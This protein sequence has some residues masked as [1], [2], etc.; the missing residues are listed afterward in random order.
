MKDNSRL[1]LLQTNLEGLDQLYRNGTPPSPALFFAALFG[2]YLEEEALARTRDG[3]PR[4]LA[5]DADMC[6][7]H[8]RYPQ[9]RLLYPGR[10]GSQLRAILALQPSLHKMPP[11]T[12][13]FHSQQA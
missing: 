4:P 7:F 10:V 3:I 6:T 1:A 2:P 11:T 13:L 9:D 8:G 12:A 5:L